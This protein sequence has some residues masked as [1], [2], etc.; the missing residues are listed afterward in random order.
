MKK[1]GKFILA[2]IL[3]A[4]VGFT[5]FTLGQNSSVSKSSSTRDAEHIAQMEGLKSLLDQNFLFDYDD[6]Q[7][8][9][10]SL[11]GMFANLGDPYTAYYTPDEFKKLMES[12]NGRYSGIGLS[13]QASKEG[14]IKAVSVFDD[15][16]AKEAGIESGDYITKVNGKAFGPNQLEEAVAEIKGEPGSDV[17]LTILRT[18]EGTT[19]SK[20]FD[21]KVTRADVNVDTIDDDI[22][23]VRGKKIG[24]IHIKAF[25]DITWKDF[26]DS[27]SKLMAQDIDGL[28]LDV[29]NNPGGAL[30]VVINIADNFL[31]EGVIVTTKDKKGNVATEKS[32]ANASDIPM[33]VL[34]NENSASA[35]EILAGAMKD[36]GRA[37]VI[38]TQSFG[39]GVVQKVFNLEDGAGAKI[40]ISEY[41]T[42]NGTQ[43]NKVGVTPDIKVESD[44]E[45]D[46]SKKDYKND[47][48]FVTGL[49]ELL[50][51][52]K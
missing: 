36:R 10:G 48:Q 26:S 19:N 52:I 14:Y 15:S 23:E 29:R 18:E 28:I 42:P 5:G 30:D 27:Y 22:L 7:I 50:K 4:G 41:F 16:P 20:E 47:K 12:L 35:S 44:E 25:D 3:V 49:N 45:L 21:V 13:V 37:K 6:E 2:L 8:Y 43:I 40:T 33:V 32:D 1:F 34:Q 17:T 39:K 51:E 46:L 31:D 24:Y 11:K 9:E 38:G